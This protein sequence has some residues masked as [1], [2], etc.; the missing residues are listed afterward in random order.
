MYLQRRLKGRFDNGRRISQTSRA[1]L[2]RVFVDAIA[3][4]AADRLKLQVTN[5]VR[6]SVNSDGMTQMVIRVLTVKQF[7]DV[8]SWRC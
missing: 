3:R 6:R 5:T 1:V 2:E 7:S 8:V 4:P